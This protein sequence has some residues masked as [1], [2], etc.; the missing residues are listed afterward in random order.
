MTS[1]L[2]NGCSLCILYIFDSF[3]RLNIAVEKAN[4]KAAPFIPQ[5]GIRTTFKIIFKIAAIRAENIKNLVLP[6]EVKVEPFGPEKL[7]KIQ[8]NDKILTTSE[9]N[10]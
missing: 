2:L 8:P 1:F 5:Q 9:A 10:T 3:I 7:L 6:N 4:E